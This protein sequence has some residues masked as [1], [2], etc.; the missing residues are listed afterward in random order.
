MLI[1]KSERVTTCLIAISLLSVGISTRWTLA[2]QADAGQEGTTKPVPIADS[3]KDKPPRSWYVLE[4]SDTQGLLH[5][6][7]QRLGKV[8]VASRRKSP[9]WTGVD[10]GGRI[11]FDI[12]VE[13]DVKGEIFVGFFAD[14]FWLAEPVQAR[15][16]PGPGQYT[17]DRLM[18]GRFHLGAMVG[19]PPHPNALGVHGEWPTPI[20]I[21][22]GQT[23]EV[24]VRVSPKFRD[25]DL[26][27]GPGD[28]KKGF[29]G[30]WAKMDPT[31][32]ITVRTVDATGKP[33]P[34]CRITLADRVK[35]DLSK[36]NSFYH[37]GTDANGYAYC[38][39]IEGPFSVL[40]AQ[41]FDVVA[42]KL[43]HRSQA[44]RSPKV[45]QAED[46]PSIV[47]QWELF[48]TGPG[49]VA[50]R[51]HDQHGRPLK[52]YYLTLTHEEGERLGMADYSAIYYHVPVIDAEG[53]YSVEGLPAGNYTAMVRHFDYPTHD[54]RFDQLRFSITKENDAAVR[55]DI[56][57]E[58][59]ELLY[60]RALYTDG[61]P[62][63]PG[64]WLTR[65][66]HDPNSAFGGEYFSLGTER[67]GSLRVTL[68]RRE[69]EALLKNSKGLV[70]IS[71]ATGELGQVHFDKLS[72]DPASPYRIVFPR[73]G[74]EK[75]HRPDLKDQSGLRPT[76]R[77]A[78][79]PVQQ[80]AHQQSPKTQSEMVDFEIL[81]LDGRTHRLSDYHGKPILLNFFSLG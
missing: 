80:S 43:I 78:S 44:R 4:Q 8:I 3:T 1:S 72:K 61:S 59:K 71:D 22:P 73:K 34:F 28:I 51:V 15:R 50:G 27:F 5:G 7:P 47:V 40:T 9:A 81:A 65:F 58:A 24:R 21:K 55:L 57:V 79:A 49:R 62:V 13:D 19:L 10:N 66:E 18:P 6:L 11:Q 74:P 52:E 29:T 56:E 17:V 68:S 45:Y 30:Q 39:E 42:D 76:A 26:S 14:P 20:E 36:I 32:L 48:P 33:V 70:R 25:N 16:F 60:G 12:S 75:P 63:Y 67:D 54:W 53:R 46:R 31:R 77:E 64:W 69:R 23:A 38:D 37:M 35:G 2:T 41:R